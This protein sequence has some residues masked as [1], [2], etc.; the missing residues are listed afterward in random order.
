MT[1]AAVFRFEV[2]YRL[3]QPSTWAYALVLAGVPFLMMHAIN[4][5]TV[6]LNAPEMVADV[7]I[8]LGLIGMLVS[9]AL[10]GDAAARDVESRM[11][12]LFYTTPLDERAYLGGRF[13]GALVTNAV[14]LLG[15]PL[16]L[17]AASVMPYMAPG[18]FGPVEPRAYVQAYLL[19]LLPNLLLSGAV[20][21][22]VAAWTR[23]TLATFLAGIV[24]LVGRAL[25]GDL[26][27]SVS[28]R[29]VA[30]LADPFGSAALS[31]VT[32]YWTL[33]ERETRLVGWPVLVLWNRALWVGVAIAVLALLLARFR[34]AHPA[35]AGRPRRR[36]A[37]AT[38][39][40]AGPIAVPSARRAFGPRTALW[41][42]LA[43]ARRALAE[44]GGSRGAL[45]VLVG[46]LLFALA[47]G[48]DVGAQVFGTSTWPVTH[49]VAGT[50]LSGALA[51]VMTL[52][53]ALFAGELVWRER[54]AGLG[55]L[56]D[57]APVPNG[58]ALLGRFLALAAMLVA[59]QAVL[60]AAGVLLQALQGYHRFELGLY[61]RMLFGLTLAG[62]VLTAVLAMTIHVVVNQKYL[63]HLIVVLYY[64]FTLFAGRL[65][66]RHHLL[67]YGSDP[68]WIYSDMNGFGPF[69]APVVWFKLYW[70]AWAL[71]LAVA[72]NLLWVRGREQGAGRR[73]ALARARFAGPPARAAAVAAALILT[74]GGFVFYNTN[75]LN[76]YRTPDGDAALGAA[77]ERRYARYAG[78]PQPRI[79]DLTLHV[80]LQP[81]AR[82]AELRGTYRLVNRT[83][84]PIDSVHVLLAEPD[85]AVRSLSFDRAAS[86][87]VTDD[88]VRYRIFAL[89]R[90]LQPG[91]S[92]QLAF[93]VAF[94]PRGFP[95][96][97]IPTAVTRHGAYLDRRW[98]PIIGYQPALELRDPEARRRQ[99]LPPR[100]PAPAPTDMAARQFR[101]EPHDADLMNVDVTIGTAADQVAITPGA[102]R[103][104]WR[105]G[106]R[107]YF[108]YRSA[109]PLPNGAPVLSARYAV[110]EGRWRDVALRIYYH[111]THDFNVDR[112]MR[113]MQASLAYYT[114]HFGPY[115]FPELRIVEFPRYASYARAH[116]HTIA[117]SEG[118]SFLTRVR[119]GD[120]DRPY[121]VTAHETAHQ[122]W[123]GQVMG[124]R[125]RGAAFLSET[126]AQ[127]SAMMVMER[128]YG[129]EQVRRFYD[130][131]MDNYLRGRRAYDNDEA[132]LLDVEDQAYVYYHKGAI[133][134][135]T[136]RERIGAA[137]V[138]S[139]LRR[140]LAR[141]RDAGPPYPTSR[142]L[143]AELRAV[144]PDSLHPL[145]RDL[146]ETI[147]LW[148]VR[149]ETAR[150]EPTG[151]G[152]YRVTLEVTASKVR[153]DSVGRE[154]PVPMDELVEIGVFADGGP[155]GGPGT[156]LYLRQH[157]VHGGR[158][159]IV[160][161][162]PRAPARAGIDPYH[163]L[164][165]RTA[166]DNVVPVAVAAVAQGAAPG[167]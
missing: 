23:Q 153:A 113:S 7:A 28:N 2:A 29:M 109:A 69:L 135:Y 159:T 53:I 6:P 63:G 19:F 26:A 114:A 45:L 132:P 107:H 122:W 10:F 35:G 156:P 22:A 60:M 47:F 127:Y 106:G 145:L 110:R 4:G 77:Y 54:D 152:A 41:Q 1:L 92:L 128:T 82:A 99:G 44:V 150:V 36:R 18:Q 15:I 30:A 40:P 14:L 131:E 138:D 119:E 50:V 96:S 80:E 66:V 70:A 155:D 141:Y 20:L 102:L 55:E 124:A 89:E 103:R 129:R 58:V 46:A 120:V 52:L 74:L 108:H 38:P 154:T 93:G 59:L 139:A 117:F 48:W 31:D 125:V 62:Y 164:I 98:L 126:M 123:G 160:V 116:P 94:R 166:D 134:M 79:T 75:V 87:V 104:E 146:F 118:S 136:L 34:F 85:V 3:R 39:A 49:L 8:I 143:Y 111:P 61:V 148:D 5:S 121:F 27:D 9:A 88:E 68:G 16:G 163:E 11:Y 157:R 130:Y 21:F 161:T 83:P 24:L 158:Q 57:A 37:A 162:V 140:Y 144:T 112:L 17:L 133:A 67:V 81:E 142:D 105:E 149:A 78:V 25:A 71:L 97:G 33:A 151:D 76:D 115:Q 137:R 100:P 167:R 64:A 73:L 165:D 91:D 56:A 72:A 51:T 101:Y 84:H 90:P 95:N 13:L 86:P 147:T 65:G 12:A 32:R 43:V 42:T